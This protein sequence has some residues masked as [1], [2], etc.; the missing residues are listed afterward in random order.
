MKDYKFCNRLKYIRE[1]A[2][3]TQTELEQK[4]DFPAKLISYYEAGTRVPGLANIKS[5]IRALGCSANELL[6]E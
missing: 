2:G 5:L 1:R 3:M 4:G 6:E